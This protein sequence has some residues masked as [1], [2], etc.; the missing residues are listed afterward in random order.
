MKTRKSD[1]PK[2][3]PPRRRQPEMRAPRPG[4]FEPIPLQIPV[5]P[6]MDD[7]RPRAKDPAAPRGVVIIQYGDET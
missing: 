4:N 3:P 1:T 7:A 6:P 5:P 2:A